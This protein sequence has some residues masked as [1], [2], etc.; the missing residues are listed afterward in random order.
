[1]LY[2]CVCAPEHGNQKSMLHILLN[3]IPP[4]FEIEY[5]THQLARLT[6]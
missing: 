2:M 6:I 3:C 5:G 4:Y 1:M